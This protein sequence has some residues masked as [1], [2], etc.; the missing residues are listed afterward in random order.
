M[1]KDLWD[2][3]AQNGRISWDSSKFTVINA[4]KT[5][6][7]HFNKVDSFLRDECEK[8]HINIVENTEL[9]SINKVI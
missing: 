3:H 6:C 1:A 4:N 7:Q 2:M 8:R 5:F 9:I